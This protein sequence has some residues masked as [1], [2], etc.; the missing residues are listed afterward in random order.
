MEA[1]R[2]V[3]V[4]GNICRTAGPGWEMGRL[5]VCSFSSC[6]TP[7]KTVHM[8]YYIDQPHTDTPSFVFFL[9]GGMTLTYDP[10]TALQNGLVLPVWKKSPWTS[11]GS[12][13]MLWWLKTVCL[14]LQV[15]LLSLQHCPKPDD[16]A[17]LP[18]PIHAFTCVHLPGTVV[19]SDPQSW[20][21]S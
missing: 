11:R 12:V 14:F 10:T 2:S 15:L 21:V 8:E 1:R 3:R 20:G 5:W 6:M 9:Q 13:I 18:L 7:V 17:D 19:V 4:R 16:W